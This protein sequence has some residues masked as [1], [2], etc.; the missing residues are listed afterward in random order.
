MS[1]EQDAIFL[2]TFTLVPTVLTV[3]GIFAAI[4]GR[5]FGNPAQT[6]GSVAEQPPAATDT[7]HE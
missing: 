7:T 5:R 1:Q 6:E 4:M 3:F 2:G